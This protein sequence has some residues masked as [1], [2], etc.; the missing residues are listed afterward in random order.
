MRRIPGGGATADAL[1]RVLDRAINK[2]GRFYVQSGKL[3]RQ[4][5]APIVGVW[6]AVAAVAPWALRAV[7]PAVTAARVG[8]G[9]FGGA[10]VANL[11]TGA[12][13]IANKAGPLIEKAKNLPGMATAAKVAGAALTAAGVFLGLRQVAPETAKQVD[14]AAAAAVR[15]TRSAAAATA[16]R[17][18]QVATQAVDAAASIPSALSTGVK[19]AAG[20]ALAAIVLP[21]VLT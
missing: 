16:R 11:R 21:K 10:L 8:L 15:K 1:D 7:G 9:R 6:P 5:P 20:L 19:W 18:R 13:F 3:K 4:G 2:G 14:D 17:A 12:S